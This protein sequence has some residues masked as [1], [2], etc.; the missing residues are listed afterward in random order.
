MSLCCGPKNVMNVQT[1][2][3]YNLPLVSL[4]GAVLKIDMR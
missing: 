1:E 3:M 4:T 2:G